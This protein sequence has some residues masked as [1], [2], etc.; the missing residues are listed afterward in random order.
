MA[1]KRLKIDIF[2][3]GFVVSEFD[4][5]IYRYCVEF[6]MRY[7][8]HT[9]VMVGHGSF[10]RP[11]QKVA[12]VY[13]GAFKNRKA[14]FFHIGQL[15]SFKK[16]LFDHYVAPEAMEIVEHPVYKP[17]RVVYHWKDKER[18][19]R[20][21]QEAIVEFIKEEEPRS[22][23][24]NAQAGYGKSLTILFSILAMQ[25]RSILIMRPQYQ[26]QWLKEIVKVFG[27]KPQE[28]VTVNGGE[29]LK[30]LIAIGD[31]PKA[32]KQ[33]KIVLMS[34]RTYQIYLKEYFES[35]GEEDW[36][37]RVPPH[38]LFQHL[39]MG[40][41]V[42]D[43]VHLDFHLNFLTLAT[44]HV[45]KSICLS[46][47]LRGD[48]PFKNRLVSML[49]PTEAFAP[50]PKYNAYI[51]LYGI[52]Y[53]IVHNEWI[54]FTDAFKH[55]SQTVYE[56]AIMRHKRIWAAYIRMIEDTV[57][58]Q[59]FRHKDYKPGMKCAVYCGMIDMCKAV[60]AA[61]AARFPTLTVSLFVGGSDEEAMLASDIVVTTLQ[62]AGTGRDIPDLIVGVSSIAISAQQANEQLVG[63]LREPKRFVNTPVR[64]IFLYNRENPKHLRYHGQRRDNL[65]GKI[66]SFHELVS[67]FLLD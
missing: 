4:D 46:A 13:A 49:F 7:V 33:L 18:S 11:E 50:T 28:V 45:P 48:N 19:P 57:H 10:R 58:W 34:N 36:E 16:L 21:T 38:A 43:E 35:N 1:T 64:F 56:K 5:E 32:L 37:Y 22:K 12:R 26:K 24:L 6:C 41:A 23:V 30:N 17:D 14:Y 63:R 20:E 47:T 3:H 39:K 51:Q 15:D 53:R 25:C 66:R 27:L 2:T 42:I 9:L 44:M 67:D 65:S 52:G 60:Q 61:L 55:Y 62:M 40:F 31:D 54:R 29:A 8:E 59:Y